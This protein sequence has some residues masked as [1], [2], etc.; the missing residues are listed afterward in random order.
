MLVEMVK[1]KKGS[2]VERKELKRQINKTIDNNRTV[3]EVLDEH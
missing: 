1:K 3:F 2:G